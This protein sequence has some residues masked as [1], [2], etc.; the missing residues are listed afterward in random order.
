MMHCIGS[1]MCFQYNC[2]LLRDSP[3]PFSWNVNSLRVTDRFAHSQDVALH[4]DAAII[5]FAHANE[6]E[7]FSTCVLELCQLVMSVHTLPFYPLHSELSIDELM[8][9]LME[10]VKA[11][12]QLFSSQLI[13]LKTLNLARGMVGA[14][15]E[16]SQWVDLDD[17]V[18][19]R[20]LQEHETG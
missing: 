2:I 7:L 12:S 9:G 19:R 1:D 20:D 13:A 5:L 14:E 3:L 11:T 16:E 17:E 18:D 4:Y 15:L 10:G 8:C 6:Q